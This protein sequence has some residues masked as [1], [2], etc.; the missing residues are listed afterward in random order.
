MAAKK[1]V[2]PPL[3]RLVGLRDD[4]AA[5]WLSAWDARKV[6]LFGWLAWAIYSWLL[7]F[8]IVKLPLL[9]FGHVLVFLVS[10]FHLKLGA[11]ALG[12]LL[13]PFMRRVIVRFKNGRM[14]LLVGDTVAREAVQADDWDAL[15]DE[16]DGQPISIVGWARGKL[17]LSRPIGGEP[18]IGVALACVQKYEGVLQSA[19]DFDLVDEHGRDIPVSVSGARLLGEPNL[20]VFSD[21][22]GRMLV[23]SLDL[24]VG[25]M[26]TGDARV[27][28]DGDPLMI[29]GF[30]DTA[31]DKSLFTIRGA[32][33]RVTVTSS[34]TRPLLIYPIA[35]ERRPAAPAGPDIDVPIDLG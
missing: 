5:A 7:Y 26:P 1:E 24:P 21:D 8:V 10:A 20:R 6:A 34:P 15:G 13:F 14:Q 31:V 33:V 25:A 27:L 16:A 18:A 23:S 19:H 9:L 28:R 29:V 2:R 35:A 22:E 32:P 11:G 4:P 17:T 3:H 30:K 12:T